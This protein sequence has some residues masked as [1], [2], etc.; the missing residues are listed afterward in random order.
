MVYELFSDSDYSDKE[1]TLGIRIARNT[2]VLNYTID[3]T[4][5]PESDAVATTNV[6]TDF[7]D[8]QL[9]VLGNTYDVIT[10]VNTSA[11]VKLTRMAIN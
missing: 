2:A 11:R 3:F 5:S 4:K 9:S 1:P 8:T 6:L 7:Q 10:A